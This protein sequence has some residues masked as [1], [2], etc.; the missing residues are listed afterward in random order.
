MRP[1]NSFKCPFF[2]PKLRHALLA[3]KFQ[4]DSA[5]LLEPSV[6]GGEADF[7]GKRECRKVGVRYQFIRRSRI[8]QQLWEFN[9]K[10]RRLRDELHTLIFHQLF[11]K[12]PSRGGGNGV[13]RH[14]MPIPEQPNKGK[15][16]ETADKGFAGGQIVKPT[17]S[18][19]MMFVMPDD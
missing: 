17:K 14:D 15:L 4:I 19:P 2:P 10:A 11:E 8:S 9:G 13:I 6:E 16:N 12:A 3:K 1:G 5:K 7:S 18:R